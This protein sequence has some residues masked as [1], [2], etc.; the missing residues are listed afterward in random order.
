MLLSRYNFFAPPPLHKSTTAPVRF[1]PFSHA[2]SVSHLQL[3]SFCSP[4]GSSQT[5]TSMRLNRG[6][7]AGTVIVLLSYRAQQPLNPHTINREKVGEG[8]GYSVNCF[9]V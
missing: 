4:F 8:G 2:H 1:P 9:T 3:F 7:L 5:L 6:S